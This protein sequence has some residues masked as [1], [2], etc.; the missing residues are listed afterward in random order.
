MERDILCGKH[1]CKESIIDDSKFI[2][3]GMSRV[4]FDDVCMEDATLNNINMQ[5][6]T[7]HYVNLK[8]AKIRD[9]HLVDVEVTG[10]EVDGM[11]IHGILVTDMMDAYE[12]LHGKGV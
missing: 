7:I 1:L 8:G 9:C 10:G 6:A 2:N 4:E 12:K 5:R 3:V 11:K